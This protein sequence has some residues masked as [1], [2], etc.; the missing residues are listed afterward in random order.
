MG[1]FLRK[2]KEEEVVHGQEEDQGLD[3]EVEGEDP[4]PDQEVDVAGQDREKDHDLVHEGVLAHVIEERDQ[5]KEGE[6]SQDLDL[7]V[8]GDL[9]NLGQ[10][11]NPKKVKNLNQVG[12]EM[13]KKI[14]REVKNQ[15]LERKRSLILTN[16]KNRM[17]K[18]LIDHQKKVLEL[19]VLVVTK[20]GLCLG[21]RAIPHL[22]KEVVHLLGRKVV[23]L[24]EKRVDLLQEEKVDQFQ[25]KKVGHL[26]GKKAVHLLG[27]KVVQYLGKKVVHLPER[28]ADLH[29]EKKVV[30]YH[31]ERVDL[32]LE[33][34]VG[35][36]GEG[37][38]RLEE[39]H[40]PEVV[41]K[42]GLPLGVE[43]DLRGKVDHLEGKGAGHLAGNVVEVLNGE[44]GLHPHHHAE[45]L[46]NLLPKTKI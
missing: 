35:H 10:D 25:E 33:G 42:V 1:F 26:R 20:V 36:P 11:L 12:I 14:K 41:E 27:R 24:H 18:K 13:R 17:I 7:K 39:D 4:D 40:D 22:I 19:G 46:Q 30:H 28:K 15:H 8:E 29:Q 43:Q 3:L 37:Q 38:D 45:D 2:R 23:L 16:I 6:Q 21:K 5:E 9:E 31:V 32:H 34:R 44:A